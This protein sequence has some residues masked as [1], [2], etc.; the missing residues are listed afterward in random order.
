MLVFDSVG[1]GVEALSEYAKANRR[2][3]FVLLTFQSG[4]GKLV[5]TCFLF[6]SEADAAGQLVANFADQ[7]RLR[8]FG[9][10]EMPGALA[11]RDVALRA[12]VA[13]PAGLGIVLEGHAEEFLIQSFDT[14]CMRVGGDIRFVTLYLSHSP[15]TPHDGN[16]SRSMSGWPISCTKKLAMLASRYP[17]YHFSVCFMERFGVLSGSASI[18]TDL[19]ALVGNPPNLAFVWQQ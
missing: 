19:K 15:C 16:A 8:G 9:R 1:E 5:P 12:E 3:V 7:L 10:A 14:C 18:E 6:K 11:A 2:T 17:R 4:G 13:A